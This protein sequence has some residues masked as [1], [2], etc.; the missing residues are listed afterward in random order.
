MKR[1]VGILFVLGACTFEHG[2]LGGPGS[3]SGSD[4]E[5]DTDGDGVADLIDNCPSSP[6][7]DQRDHDKDS[8]GDV[9]DPC[10][11]VADTWQDLDGDGVGD[12]CDPHPDTP[13]DRIVYFEGFYDP[14]SWSPVIGSNTWQVENGTLHQN[15][16]DAV[17]QLVRDAAD[18]HELFVDARV[19]VN[20]L[21]STSS[22]HSTSLV[23][24][25]RDPDRFFFCSL[26]TEGAG[27]DVN[28][29]EQYL[30]G[31]GTPLFDYNVAAFDTQ[32]TGDWATLQA[33]L[34]ASSVTCTTRR[35][36]AFATTSFARL[37]TS[38]GDL[39]LRTNEA[40]A[41]FDYVF[42]VEVPAGSP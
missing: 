31:F 42:V 33:R 24:G 7:A 29:G 8:R 22:R 16:T 25:Y 17:Y 34:H 23:L 2:Q 32:M 20:A 30:D 14:V 15:R 27:A 41:S 19:R 5:Q 35:G 12:A 36:A 40:D 38:T 10:P 37:D 3:G 9:C 21:G 13:G 1:V 4:P 11:H 28:A 18:L 39:G 6:N 26:A